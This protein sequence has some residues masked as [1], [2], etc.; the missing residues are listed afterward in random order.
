M[1]PKSLFLRW[2]GAGSPEYRQNSHLNFVCLKIGLGVLDMGV[3][4]IVVNA[5][6]TFNLNSATGDNGIHPRLLRA[7]SNNVGLKQ[8]FI[9]NLLVTMWKIWT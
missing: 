6:S 2:L 8:L 5:I 3:N 7:L 4:P 1:V 9:F